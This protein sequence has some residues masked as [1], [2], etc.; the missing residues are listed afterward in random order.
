MMLAPAPTLGVVIAPGGGAALPGTGL[1]GTVEHDVLI[2]FEVRSPGGVLFFAA[3][4][5]NRVLRLADGK[6]AFLYQVRDSQ[7]GLN[8]SVIEVE[9]CQLPVCLAAPVQRRSI[10]LLP[11]RHRR[12]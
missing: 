9:H 2:D 3:K 8:G 11:R 10:S 7:T 1:A 12:G 5:Q 6:L 4:L